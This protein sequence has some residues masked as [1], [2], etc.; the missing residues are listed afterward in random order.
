MSS[1]ADCISSV[2]IILWY[3]MHHHPK[4]LDEE[5]VYLP[6]R[7][8]TQFIIEGS[9]SRNSSRA[10]NWRKELKQTLWRGI[11]YWIFPPW[12]TLFVFMCNLSMPNLH[13]GDM[14]HSVLGPPISIVNHP[15]HLLTGQSNR[16]IFS[17]EATCFQMT[18]NQPKH[19]LKVV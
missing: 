5:R 4:H 15:I 6:F 14:V 11:T 17:I 2:C 12:L 3:N 7:S 16:I 19:W 13:R 9:Q 10:R 1:S 18:E 8:L